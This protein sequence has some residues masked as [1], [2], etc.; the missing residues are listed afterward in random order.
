MKSTIEDR[1]KAASK[2]FQDT[3]ESWSDRYR[4]DQGL[5]HSFLIR[6]QAVEWQLGRIPGRQHERAL[7]LGCGTGPY[8]R[9]LSRLAREVVGVDVAPAMIEEAKRN[10]PPGL[11][12]VRLVVASVFDLPF[13]DAH[14]D[15]GICVGVLEYFDD[16]VAVLRAAFRV[17]KPGGSLVFTVP[18]VFGIAR[19]TGLPRTVTLLVPPGWKVRVGAIFDRVCGRE[20]DPSRYYLGASFTSSR[21]CRFCEE[22]G[23]ELAEMTT[24]GYDGLRFAGIPVR[25]RFASALDRRGESRRHNFPWRRFGNNLIVSIR[26]PLL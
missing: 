20:P 3:A 12:T 10:L 13:P 16:P 26:K 24:S 7:D 23:L 11:D 25:A 5:S 14:F 9:I 17:M 15:L 4:E 2:H 22:A 1:N 8:L 6:R 18:N 21:M 19:L